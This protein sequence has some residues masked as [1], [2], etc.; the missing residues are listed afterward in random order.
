V[1]FR[2]RFTSCDNIDV[3]CNAEDPW[4]AAEFAL[5]GDQLDVYE[6]GMYEGPAEIPQFLHD[7]I[8]KGGRRSKGLFYFEAVLG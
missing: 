5:G 4:E 2:Y 3:S 8:A 7:Q 1:T 6:Q